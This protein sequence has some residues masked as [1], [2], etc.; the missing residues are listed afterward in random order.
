MSTVSG[1]G[2][3]TPACGPPHPFAELVRDRRSPPL[4]QWNPDPSGELDL[5]ITA[6]GRWLHEGREIRRPALVR[7]LASVLRR[8]EDGCHYLVS[9]FEKYR[10][11]V[12]DTALVAVD[13]EAEGHGACQRLW[14]RTNVD[15][16]VV[17]GPGHAIEVDRNGV[18]ANAGAPR[19]HVRDGLEAVLTRPV[20]Y[21]LAERV[22]ERPGRGL[23][24]WSGGVFFVLAGE[25][26]PDGAAGER[27]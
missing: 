18:G 5:R 4:Q 12:D 21:R 11:R 6:D 1:N 27:T 10:I 13:M 26:E 19:I 17:A 22:E 3:R 2:V 20:Y 14:F 24:V 15:D 9:P 16:V 8:E 25:S 23:G 7:L